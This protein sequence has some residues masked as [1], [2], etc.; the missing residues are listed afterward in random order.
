MGGNMKENYS[1]MAQTHMSHVTYVTRHDHTLSRHPAGEINK[2][3]FALFTCFKQTYLS[4][5]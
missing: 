1:K 5:Y 3:R 2:P 4:Y